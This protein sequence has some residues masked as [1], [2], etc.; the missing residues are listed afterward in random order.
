MSDTHLQQTLDLSIPSQRTFESYITTTNQEQK[1]MLAFYV[2][3]PSESMIVLKGDVGTGKTHLL[4]AA[5]HLYQSSG[6]KASYIPMKNPSDLEAL[7]SKPLQGEL[8]CIDNVHLSAQHDDLEHL[9][10][11]LYKHP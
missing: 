3:N 9:L 8:I 6:R 2:K 11:I 1:T 4:H 7:L 10:F 5:C